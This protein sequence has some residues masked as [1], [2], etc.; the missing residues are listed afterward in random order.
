M[1]RIN[2][3]IWLWRTPYCL[4]VEYGTRKMCSWSYRVWEYYHD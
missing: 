3:D 4:C 1:P 2:A